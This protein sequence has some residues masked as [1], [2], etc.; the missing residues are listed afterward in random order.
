[1][2]RAGDWKL[3]EQGASYY[4]W[5]EQPLQL[6]N[7]REDPYEKHNRAAEQPQ[8]VSKLRERLAYYRGQARKEEPPGRIPGGPPAVYGEEE[9]AKF[10][11][12]VREQAAALK[13]TDQDAKSQRRRKK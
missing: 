12:W 3:I 13:L 9:N 8:I 11:T 4:T 10:G 2:I 7:I 1:V 5:E 6:Y